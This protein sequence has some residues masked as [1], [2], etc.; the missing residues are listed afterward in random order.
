MQDE[1]MIK[2]VKGV[3]RKPN[4]SICDHNRAQST[5]LCLRFSSRALTTKGFPINVSSVGREGK[6]RYQILWNSKAAI[7]RCDL[8][9]HL[10]LNPSQQ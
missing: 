4:C 2:K 9:K 10:S 1:R 5:E 3:L 6:L 7:Q 8:K